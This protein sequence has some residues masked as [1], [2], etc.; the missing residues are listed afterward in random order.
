MIAD[1]Y[2]ILQKNRLTSSAILNIHALGIKHILQLLFFK[3][4]LIPC[5]QLLE[6]V[7][8][9]LLDLQLVLVQLIFAFNV[10]VILE[11]TDLKNILK[12]KVRSLHIK[13][14]KKKQFKKTTK[15]F[16]TT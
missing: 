15:V 13:C 5:N 1:K 16:Y 7:F 9:L 6:V 11:N 3:T 2:C 10:G 12:M 8:D 14:T 4:S